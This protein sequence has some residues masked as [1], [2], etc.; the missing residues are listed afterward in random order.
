[1]RIHYVLMTATAAVYAATAELFVQG[2]RKVRHPDGGCT[3]APGDYAVVALVICAVLVIGTSAWI[4]RTERERWMV[5]T[6]LHAALPAALGTLAGMRYYDLRMPRASTC[7]E[8][9]FCGW[10]LNTVWESAWFNAALASVA[11]M[12]IALA[13]GSVAGA[14]RRP[15]PT[16]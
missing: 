6:G 13:T 2:D 16:R 11:T 14:V 4:A 3:D 7:L 10:C 15:S 5:S 12:L 9:E 8:L 1:M